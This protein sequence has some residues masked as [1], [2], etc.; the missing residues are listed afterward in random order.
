[1]ANITKPTDINKIWSSGGDIIAPSDT[2]IQGGW[3][4]EIP[5]RQYFNYI[6]N[7]QDQAIA[8]INQ[9]G[10]AVWDSVTEYQAGA[11]YVQG[12]DGY[13]YKARTTNTNIDPTTDVSFVNW[14][15]AIIGGLL[16]VRTFTSTSV[17]TPTPGTRAV[18]VKVQAGGGAGGGA[19]STTTGFWALGGGGG[20]GGYSESYITSGFSG[21]TV[22][23]G[24]GGTPASGANGGAGGSSSFGALLSATG[25]AGGL[26]GT[27][28]NSAG[29]LTAG[30]AGGSGSSGNIVN[31]NGAQ[32]GPSNGH[33]TANWLTGVGGFSQFGAGGVSLAAP[34]S[35]NGSPASSKGAGGSGGASF[36]GGGAQSG[37][38]GAAGVVIVW[39][40]N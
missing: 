35:G 23:V 32:G 8:H 39:E 10:I 28:I 11:S 17:Y 9:H 38:A 20:A 31:S 29:V 36:G 4:T 14:T 6:D 21:V 3:L 12:S 33:D 30:G 25:G 27:S 26:V 1:M 16:N 2:K 24:A 22:T 37:G 18:L 19:A 13:I 5:P 40:F 15:R 7:K 34:G